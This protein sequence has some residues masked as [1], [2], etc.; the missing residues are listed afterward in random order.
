MIDKGEGTGEGEGVGRYAWRRGE[1]RG[2][3]LTVKRNA[4]VLYFTLRGSHTK[5]PLLILTWEYTHTN[6]A[7][8]SPLP[9]PPIEMLQDIPGYA[10]VQS[11]FSNYDAKFT[12]D[13]QRN[14]TTVYT[15]H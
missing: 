6:K 4:I 2:M 14:Y 1:G 3:I 12:V 15:L 13:T 5:L 9:I 11:R 8:N 10:S 7:I